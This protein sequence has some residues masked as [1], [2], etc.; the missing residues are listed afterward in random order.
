MMMIF[1]NNNYYRRQVAKV[2]SFHFGKH[3]NLNNK[4]EIDYKMEPNY[5]HNK[6]KREEYLII[7]SDN[8]N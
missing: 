6:V 8:P 1:N 3:K 2:D 5:H 7:Y 4:K